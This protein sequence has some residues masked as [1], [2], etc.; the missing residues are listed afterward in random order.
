MKLTLGGEKSTDKNYSELN[1]LVDVKKKEKNKRRNS[2]GKRKKG[3][4]EK[5][6]EK[7]QKK[8]RKMKEKG[9]LLL[10]LARFVSSAWH[11]K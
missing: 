4:N 8:K 11:S 10:L 6:R 1:Q 9:V 7:G 5:G 2:K 3:K